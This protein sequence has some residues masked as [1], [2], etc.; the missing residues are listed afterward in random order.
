MRH[1]L[2]K[3]YKNVYIRQV[4]REDIEMLRKWRN[5]PINTRYLRKL[6]YITKEMQIDWYKGYLN[7]K[8]EMMFA[9]EETE[10]LRRVVG[11]LALYNF[12]EEQTEVGKL[13]IGDIEAHGRGIGVNSLKAVLGL[14]FHE[15]KKERVVLHVYSRNLAAVRIYKKV[16][17]EILE[18]HLNNGMEELTM[19]INKEKYMSEEYYA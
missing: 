3:K 10:E 17:F 18:K 4:E 8:D 16:G 15:L 2:A 11:S 13:L 6:P 7:S 19:N 1:D 5:N 14:V 9:I 12:K